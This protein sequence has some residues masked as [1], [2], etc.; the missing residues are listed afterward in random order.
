MTLYIAPSTLTTTVFPEGEGRGLYTNSIILPGEI[1]DDHW[2]FLNDS[3]VNL[4]AISS[5]N[6][7]QEFYDALKNLVE[8]YYADDNIG[9]NSINVQ[10]EYRHYRAIKTIN[11]GEELFCEYGIKCWLHIVG[12]YTKVTTYRGYLKYIRELK[13]KDDKLISDG[14]IKMLHADLDTVFANDITNGWMHS[15]WQKNKPSPS[16]RIFSYFMC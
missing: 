2:L 10:L 13:L 5:A 15:L 11:I 6:S 1:I 14:D 16:N 9:C 8:S 7:D 4:T 12:W 3:R